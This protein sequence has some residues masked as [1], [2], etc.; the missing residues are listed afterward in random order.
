MLYPNTSVKEWS[1]RYGIK[2]YSRPC[3]NCGAMQTTDIPY[4]MNGWRG[5]KSAVCSC[6]GGCDIDVAMP[7][8]EGTEL[9]RALFEDVKAAVNG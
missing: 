3:V 1:A 4:A 6:G 9:W 2:S 5:L 8:G 7:V